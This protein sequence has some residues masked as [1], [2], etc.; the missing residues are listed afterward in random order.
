MGQSQRAPV[1]VAQPQ[2]WPPSPYRATLPSSYTACPPLFTLHMVWRPL[3][4]A[5]AKATQMLAS[6]LTVLLQHTPC[7]L[8]DPCL[9]A[10]TVAQT[11]G[12]RQQVSACTVQSRAAQLKQNGW[13]L[14]AHLNIQSGGLDI[15]TV[16]S[17][18]PHRLAALVQLHM[19]AHTQPRQAH[20]RNQG[21]PPCIRGAS[22]KP[23]NVLHKREEPTACLKHRHCWSHPHSLA[24]LSC[25]QQAT[26][27]GCRRFRQGCCHST[28][29]QGCCHSTRPGVPV[30]QCATHQA[31][32]PYKFERGYQSYKQGYW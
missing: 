4:H 13:R 27:P 30:W 8:S 31:L 18:G 23:L 16:S 28:L 14:Q 11:Q 7:M 3:Y 21:C 26:G 2:N 9:P 5:F 22:E 17:S 12:A 19:Q 24:L 10:V 20:L 15:P 25:C 6:G 1:L 29:R 32:Q